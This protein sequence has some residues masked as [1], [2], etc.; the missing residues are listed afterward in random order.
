MTTAQQTIPANGTRMSFA[1]YQMLGLP[2][3][4]PC[5]LFGGIVVVDDALADQE[6]SAITKRGWLHAKIEA[7]TA[8]LLL[9]WLDS[10]GF[11]GRVG[12]GEV[13]C[14]DPESG[15]DA[16]IDVA[17]FPEAVIGSEIG[18]GYVRGVPLLAVE[19]VS[20]SDQHSKVKAKVDGYLAAGVHVVWVVDP[21]FETVA[22]HTPGNPPQVKSG[23]D[24]VIVADL[25]P[26]FV[27][28]ASQFFR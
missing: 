3:D 10:T 17:V 2:A 24:D 13:G 20:P 22:I 14:E 23:E 15:L 5:G 26:G 1:E 16:G 19:I 18:A 11:A 25:L 9:N 6:E 8:Q 12:S 28:P 4:S 7:R 21:C 27:N